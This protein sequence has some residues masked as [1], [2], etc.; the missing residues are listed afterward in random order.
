MGSMPPSFTPPNEAISVEMIPSL[1]LTVGDTP[2]EAN[3]AALEIDRDLLPPCLLA[4]R[5]GER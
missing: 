3:F 1:L 2:A 4:G 5:E